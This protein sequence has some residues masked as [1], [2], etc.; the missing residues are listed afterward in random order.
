VAEQLDFT[1]H[2]LGIDG[3]LKAA[4][5]LLDCHLLIALTVAGRAGG[6][7]GKEDRI[8]GQRVAE[9]VASAFEGMG[10]SLL[11]GPASNMLHWAQMLWAI[12]SDIRSL[13]PIGA[14]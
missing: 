14:G 4:T 6:A 1:Q 10:H 12:C 3:A 11:A 7:Q 13:K 8:R 2:A 5:D 9:G